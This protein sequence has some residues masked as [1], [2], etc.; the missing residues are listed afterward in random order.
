MNNLKNNT[1]YS[2]RMIK[3]GVALLIYT[4]I[5]IYAFNTLPII[6]QNFK[7]KESLIAGVE[8]TYTEFVNINYSSP[9]DLFKISSILFFIIIIISGILIRDLDH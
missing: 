8:K 5:I 9:Y 4:F 2:L 3:R 7:I 6:F 1:L